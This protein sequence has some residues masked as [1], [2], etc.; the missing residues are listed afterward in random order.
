M[1]FVVVLPLRCKVPVAAFVQL[2]LALFPFIPL[3]LDAVTVPLLVMVIAPLI[4]TGQDQIW[5]AVDAMLWLL[6]EKVRVPVVE[7]VPVPS[8]IAAEPLSVTAPE[9]VPL[10]VPLLVKL[11]D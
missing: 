6:V 7:T 11:P 1:K 4:K 5:L 9:L 2:E 8:I 10:K 3:A